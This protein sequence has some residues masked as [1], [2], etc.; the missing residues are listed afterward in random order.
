MDLEIHH[1]SIGPPDGRCILCGKPTY[2][3]YEFTPKDPKKYGF[4]NSSRHGKSHVI[5]IAVCE[6]HPEDRETRLE[7]LRRLAAPG[8]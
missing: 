8:N 3:Y 5:Y 6:E 7:I 2:L 4:K 1:G